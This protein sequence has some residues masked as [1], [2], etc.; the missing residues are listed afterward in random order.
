S[1]CSPP[2]STTMP[3]ACRPAVGALRAIELAKMTK[4]PQNANSTAA[5][6]PA[7]Y[8]PLRATTPLQRSSPAWAWPSN[9]Y[10]SRLGR[11]CD[12]WAPAPQT[13]FPR[14]REH[15]SAS[16]LEDPVDA[17]ARGEH[18]QGGDHQHDDA[19]QKIAH[20]I[21]RRDADQT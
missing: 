9:D 20:R 19:E 1:R 2:V 6:A 12:P 18:A 7:R 15:R 10:I 13:V 5:T 17:D 8:L 21:E 3:S 4:P 14:R 11:A 16:M